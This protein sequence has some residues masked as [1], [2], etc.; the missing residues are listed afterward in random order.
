[1]RIKIYN[2]NFKEVDMR[3]ERQRFNYFDD[4]LFNIVLEPVIL[5]DN[6][7]RWDYAPIRP[8]SYI[9]YIQIAQMLN[10]PIFDYVK[11]LI[12]N[13]A[14]LMNGNIYGFEYIEE[15]EKALLDLEAYLILEKLTQ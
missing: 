10:I 8:S 7:T 15:V 12:N 9:D 6:F 3:I 1:M 13:K 14:F 2:Y 5:Q 11:I 4:V